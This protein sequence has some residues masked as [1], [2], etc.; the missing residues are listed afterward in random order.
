MSFLTRLISSARIILLPTVFF[1]SRSLLFMLGSFSVNFFFQIE[2]FRLRVPCKPILLDQSPWFPLG[3][4]SI[5]S[6]FLD[7]TLYFLFGAF[8]EKLFF[9]LHR[10][11]F[12]VHNRYVQCKFLSF[13]TIFSVTILRVLCK[14]IFLTET[15]CRQQNYSSTCSTCDFSLVWLPI[16]IILCLLQTV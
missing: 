1:S 11:F 3:E 15:Y 13:E 4:L 2:Y 12:L 10:I 8:S 16:F 5:N 7:K 6:Y 9:F 14:L